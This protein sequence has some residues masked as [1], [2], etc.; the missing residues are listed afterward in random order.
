M[1]D[2]S[3]EFV[4]FA[5]QHGLVI[6]TL[7]CGRFQRCTTLESSRGKLDGSYYFTGSDGW[8][9]NWRRQGSTHWLADAAEA[10]ESQEDT[11]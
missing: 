1:R 9:R 10:A 2:R 3:A 5:L 11:D 7:V 4:R 6:S 8:V